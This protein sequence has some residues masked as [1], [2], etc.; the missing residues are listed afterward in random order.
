MDFISLT[1]SRSGA[2]F[3]LRP[4]QDVGIDG[5]IEFRNE[6]GQPTGAIALVQSKAG[7]SYITASGEYH[8]RAKKQHFTI[9]S[10]YTL[11]VI[12]IVY[13]P[14]ALDARWVNISE[15]LR[16]NPGCIENGPYVIEAPASQP[17]SEQEFPKFQEVIERLHTR[18]GPQSPSELINRY[19]TGEPA[20]KEE[21]LTELFSGFR[22][23]PLACFF[24]HQ[25]LRI[26]TDQSIIAYLTY[27]LSFYRHY[28]DRF[29]TQHNY[30]PLELDALAS[31]CID[32]FGVAEVVKMLSTIDPENGI[33]RGSMG[34]LVA[35]QLRAITDIVPKMHFII[36]NRE[37]ET[38]IRFHAI[39]ILVEYLEDNDYS[40]YERTLGMEQDSSLVEALRWALESLRDSLP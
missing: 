28:E 25:A 32:G 15:Y 27:L 5:H 38:E 11:P 17:F 10:K 4:R 35:I 30:R 39:V 2:F 13:N 8:I 20:I 40:F 7:I 36:E 37:L 21:V 6:Q 16:A 34:Q 19:L 33:D 26:E 1:C 29:Y 18:L 12:G 23:T 9:W 24:I 31:K 3:L 14:T 22:W